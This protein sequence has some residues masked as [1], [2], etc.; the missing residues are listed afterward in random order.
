MKTL[1]LA[2]TNQAKLGELSMG[3]RDMF[4]GSVKIATLRQLGIKQEPEETGRTFRD[5]ARIKAKYYGE[6]TKLPTIAD[7]GG[8]L[9]P[10]L[11][12][13]P[14]VKSR[15]WLGHE[16][17]DRELIN[18]TLKH[19]RGVTWADRTAYLQTSLCFYH[20][21]TGKLSYETEKIKGHIAR[22]PSGRAT[23]GYPYRALFIVA[24]FDKYYDELTDK[25][26]FQINH[27]LKALQ[28]LLKKI[29]PDLLQLIHA[30]Y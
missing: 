25:E 8:L 18:H 10:Y 6:I 21:Q 23:D 15:R 30:V 14:G 29:A 9:I 27:R 7:D 28:R 12:N 11:N 20:P 2:T 1:L 16:A 13:E 22:K 17:G 4:A 24:A 26:H 19:L 5:N 3:V